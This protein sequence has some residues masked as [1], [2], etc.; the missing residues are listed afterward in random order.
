MG[1]GDDFNDEV[2]ACLDRI[3]EN[4][5]IYVFIRRPNI[6]GAK[7]KRFTDYSMVYEVIS[8]HHINVYA[9]FSWR[10]DIDELLERFPKP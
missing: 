9:V 8:D 5:H 4:P 2:E 6:R 1:L 3:K 7:L 10:R